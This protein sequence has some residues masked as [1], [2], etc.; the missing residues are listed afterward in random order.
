[1]GI[2]YKMP[3]NAT[4]LVVTNAEFAVDNATY[5]NVTILNPSNSVSD[6]N[7]TA[8]HLSVEGKNETYDITDVEVYGVTGSEPIDFPY[9]IRKGTEPIFKCNKNWSNFAG[10]TVRIE[11]AAAN[12]STRSYSYSTPNVKLN[13]K[14]N[15]D[16]QIFQSIEYFNLTIENWQAKPTI[17]LTISEIIVNDSPVNT[18]QP[19]P[20]V[21]SPNQTEIFRCERNW[22]D[23]MGVNVTITVKTLEGYESVYVTNELPGAILFVDEINFDYADTAYFNLTLSSSEYSTATAIINKV[24][25][26]L[27]DGTTMTL[28]TTPPLHIIPIPI[29]PNQSSTIKCLGWDW[30]MSRNETITV[31][32]YT[33]QGFTAPS[34]TVTTPPAI[35]WN[36]T[37]VKFDLDDIEHF[38]LNVTNMP[39]SLNAVNATKIEFNQNSTDMNPTLIA[40]GEQ[41]TFNCG[42]NWS[43]FAGQ[44]ITITV[45]VTYDENES[46]ISYALKLPY[47]KIRNVSFFNFPLGNPYAN[48]TIYNSEFSKINANITRMFIQTDNETSPIDGTITSPRISSEGYQ[49]VIGAE[50]TIVCPWDWSPYFGKYVTVIVQTADGYQVSMALKVE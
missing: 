24:N 20:Y 18:T 25:L 49:L 6:A 39:C 27:A 44:D 32:V 3:E 41:A 12:A 28:N 14:P 23:L 22:E 35:V 4:L 10:E 1:M 38:T 8:I 19:L 37:D 13:V 30:N 33:E 11:P 2:Y 43:S 46:S 48:V 15:F 42:F 21:L 7:I 50:V 26:T 40:A 17:N 29:P 31:T 45:H 47:L 36:I 34:K 9:T 5:F 16:E